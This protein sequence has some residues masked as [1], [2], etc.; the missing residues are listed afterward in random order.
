MTNPKLSL[1]I[2]TLAVPTIDDA[3]AFYTS[4]YS[5]GG[6]SLDLHGAGQLDL[7]A[8][9]SSVAS[10]EF[11]G[12]VVSYIVD[13]PSEVESLL[14][15]A[16][17]AGGEVLKPA[18]KGFFGGFTAVFRAPDGAIWKLATDKKKN[19]GPAAE[20]PTPTETVCI[21]GVDD[22]K[23]SMAFYTALGMTVDRDYGKKF[24]DFEFD[25]GTSRLGLLRRSELAKDAGVSDS[26]RGGG[27]S[28]LVSRQQSRADVDTLLAAA[29]SAGGQVT[30][31]AG[32]V[33]GGYAG[34]FTDPDGFIWKVASN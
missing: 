3:R 23:A 19:S 33:D 22:P 16:A 24:I 2:L 20:P 5:L 17:A 34:Q 31:P 25:A 12:L 7:D 1:D 18:K 32:A 4:T 30:A 8:A 15:A 6:T 27:T 13:Q 14:A 26:G 21:L 9:V 11:P 10:T 28:V 29:T